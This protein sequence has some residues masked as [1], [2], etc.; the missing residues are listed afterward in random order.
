MFLIWHALPQAQSCDE[1][2]HPTST[3]TARPCPP[4]Q[5]T[6]RTVEAEAQAAVSP[7]DGIIYGSCLLKL[8]SSRTGIEGS[9]RL[10][11]LCLLC[12]FFFS[13]HN[14][15]HHELIRGETVCGVVPFSLL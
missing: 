15:R 12:F 13:L 5:L 14:V 11:L 1:L 4:V 10:A 9:R 2:E 7:L 8:Q 6:L 3:P